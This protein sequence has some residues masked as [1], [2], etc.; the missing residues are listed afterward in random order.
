MFPA[1]PVFTFCSPPYPVFPFCS[2]FV[3]ALFSFCTRSRFVLVLFFCVLVS[4][5]VCSFGRSLTHRDH[6]LTFGLG[7]G[8][9]LMSRPNI[10][11]FSSDTPPQEGL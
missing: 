11:A 9:R 1:P 2:R 4:F 3:H 5:T 8:Y 7:L 10:N 6:P